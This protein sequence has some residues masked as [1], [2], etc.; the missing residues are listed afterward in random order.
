M[1]STIAGFVEPGES[2]E[3]CVAREVLEETGVEVRAVHYHSSQP[4]PF[5][6]SIM[7]GFVAEAER[8]NISIDD[9]NDTELEDAR[10]FSRNDMQTAIENGTLR[11]PGPISIAYRLIEYWFDSDSGVPLKDIINSR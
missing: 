1:Y 4:W 5:P 11:F 3:S 7:L 2:L 10:W 9:I 6:C 8:K